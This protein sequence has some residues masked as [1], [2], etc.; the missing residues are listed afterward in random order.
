[1]TETALDPGILTLQRR[2]SWLRPLLA[3]G[4]VGTLGLLIVELMITFGGYLFPSEDDPLLRAYQA[5]AIGFVVA[6]IVTIIVF[7]MWIH[8]A[9]ANVQEAGTPGFEYTPGWAV[10]WYF[11]PFAN[12]VKPFNAMR[13]I[14][15]ASHGGS[16]SYLNEGNSL[17]TAWWLFWLVSSILA[18]ISFRVS[19]GSTDPDTLRLSS[20]VGI[21]GMVADLILYPLA[22]QLVTKIT[23]AQRTRMDVVQTFA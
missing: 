20:M 19:M 21:G 11:I 22:L 3:I 6:N 16:G 4:W 12:L 18:N 15:N 13:Q 2:F 10:G 14:W 17:L 8:R 7:G 5:F 23:E 9:A 1:M